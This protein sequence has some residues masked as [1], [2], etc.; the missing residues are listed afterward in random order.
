MP[1]LTGPPAKSQLGRNR[2][3]EGVSSI[4]WLFWRKSHLGNPRDTFP[5]LDQEPPSVQLHTPILPGNL[6][7]NGAWACPLTGSVACFT[8]EAWELGGGVSSTSSFW[9]SGGRR[10]L[11]DGPGDVAIVRV[12]SLSLI[13]CMTLSDF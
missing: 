7:V 8:E 10:G 4:R 13:R 11:G 5:A 9:A 2:V 6:R 3:R 1:Y 12:Q